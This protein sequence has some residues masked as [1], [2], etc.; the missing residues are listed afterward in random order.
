MIFSQLVR[1]ALTGNNFL[2][3]VSGFLPCDPSSTGPVSLVLTLVELVL[4]L[5]HWVCL[6]LASYT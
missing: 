1:A 2:C 4:P 5:L 6:L 3:V